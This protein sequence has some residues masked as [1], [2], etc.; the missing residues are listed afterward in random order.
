MY[1]NLILLVLGLF[2]VISCGGSGDGDGS[3]S[4]GDVVVACGSGSS[5]YYG[6]WRTIGCQSVQNPF[7]SESVWGI[8]RFNFAS[9]GT[10][11][12][13]GKI[14]TNSNCTGSTVYEWEGAT[15]F[16]FTEL[17][18]ETLPSGLTGYRLH[19]EDVT[20]NGQGTSEVLVAVTA[21]SQLCLSS[22]F[23]L[24]SAEAY[25]FVFNQTPAD[26]DL[27]NNCLDPI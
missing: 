2:L 6:C 19:V 11:Y 18:M 26:V 3:G 8:N 14:Y 22:S 25:V 24:A 5:P 27:V 20:T 23:Q 7:G 21:N 15:D 13:M 17:D 12:E 10:I 1:K 16:S 4:G 9:D